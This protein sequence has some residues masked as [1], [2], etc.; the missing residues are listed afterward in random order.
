MKITTWNVERLDLAWGVAERRCVR[1]AGARGNRNDP[2]LDRART[3]LAAV[4]AEVRRIDHIDFT[5]A[6]TRSGSTPL[7]VP[8]EAAMAEHVIDDETGGLFGRDVASG[9]RPVSPTLQPHPVA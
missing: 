5:R 6:F 2:T 8:P 1:G 4:G 3:R 7:R 9:H